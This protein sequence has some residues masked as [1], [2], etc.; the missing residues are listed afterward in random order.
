MFRAGSQR[1]LTEFRT[2]CPAKRSEYKIGQS[3]L[4]YGPKHLD[5]G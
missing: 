2:L 3:A 4:H 1:Y 5:S